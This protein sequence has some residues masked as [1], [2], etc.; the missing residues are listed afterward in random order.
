M[1]IT[2]TIFQNL[3]HSLLERPVKTVITF[4][5]FKNH[6]QLNIF[7]TY[8]IIFKYLKINVILMELGT[9]DRTAGRM[10]SLLQHI[11]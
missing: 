9:Y 7:I 5:T 2:I 4:I 10:A 3:K 11:R 1:Y 6:K 8:G